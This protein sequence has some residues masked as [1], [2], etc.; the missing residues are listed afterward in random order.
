MSRNFF[1]YSNFSNAALSF[2]LYG[3]MIVHSLDTYNQFG[4][5]YKKTKFK[6]RLLTDP[7]SVEEAAASPLFNSKTIAKISSLF[8]SKKTNLFVF[9]GRIDDLNA[10]HVYMEDPCSLDYAGTQQE[11]VELISLHTT[12]VSTASGARQQVKAGDTVNVLLS[13]GTFSYN[14]EY[15]EF[16]G[17][18][19]SSDGAQ[20]NERNK[21]CQELSSLFTKFKFQ[22]IQTMGA[23]FTAAEAVPCNA[24][25]L[26]TGFV[27]AKHYTP[28]SRGA[29]QIRMIVVHATAGRSGA[30]RAKAS[31]SSMA[32]GSLRAVTATS[33]WKGPTVMY[34][35]K[36]RE[37]C[38]SGKCLETGAAYQLK[39]AKASAHYFVD[40]GGAVWQGVLD[41]DIAWHATSTNRYSIG[42][43]HNGSAKAG[44]GHEW[45]E[46]LYQASA[47]LSAGL[48][49]KYNIPIVRAADYRGS[50]FL[51]HKEVPNQSH[52][53]P[54]P[55]WNWGKYL[56]LV[57]QYA[58]S[59]N[60]VAIGGAAGTSSGE[61]SGGEDD[62]SREP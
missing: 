10:P 53:D 33:S 4:T 48:A 23:P 15:G 21:I 49:A 13:K 35:G 52:V 44:D 6:A 12:F 8:S 55:E 29:D 7:F 54:G 39:E 9:K 28:S 41:K 46:A 50:G 1:D 24:G 51:E 19:N 11:I 17:L 5:N 26:C 36:E 14:L 59:G 3:N 60:F 58:N 37:A 30:G 61:D 42:I 20:K 56:A 57:R 38:H 62:P 16:V 40:Q 45:N 47:R 31:A 2:A 25:A 34:A 18:V 32:R 22:P 27:Q 43:E